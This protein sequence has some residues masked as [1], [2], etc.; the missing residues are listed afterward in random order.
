MADTITLEQFS[1]LTWP[2]HRATCSPWPRCSSTSWAYRATPITAGFGMAPF[3]PAGTRP[4]TL[5][6][7]RLVDRIGAAARIRLLEPPGPPS[8]SPVPRLQ[9][10]TEIMAWTS[11]PDG[12]LPTAGCDRP[13][14]P[15]PPSRSTRHRTQRTQ[16]VIDPV[17]RSP[18]RT[19]QQGCCAPSDC[20]RAWEVTG[21][22]PDVHARQRAS[23]DWPWRRN[24]PP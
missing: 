11:R 6:H 14:W 21:D 10:I 1:W 9:P 7:E 22:A 12:D 18:C 24:R 2:P 15:S 23:V 20:F 8:P 19:L 17:E 3:L 4:I 13:R 5:V 16:P